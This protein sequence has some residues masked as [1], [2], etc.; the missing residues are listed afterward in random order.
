MDTSDGAAL[1]P[2]IISGGAPVPSPPPKCRRF[3]RLIDWQSF[4]L[5]ALLIFA[6]Y[7]F[8][9]SP[10]I[11]L[12][13][14]GILSTG[15]MY[16]GVPHP[17]GFPL[18]TIYA[19][20]FTVLIPFGNIA[21]RVAISSAIATSIACGLVALLVS[22]C[23]TLLMEGLQK[24]QRLPPKSERWLRIVCGCVAGMSFGLSGSVWSHS[25]VANWWPLTFAMFAAVICLLVRWSFTPEKTRYLYEAF[26]LYGL[27]LTKSQSL[28]VA[29]LG[30]EL[31]I[32]LVNPALGRDLFAVSAW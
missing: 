16:G 24:F 15:A 5:T 31:F 22:R 9:L 25:V 6:V 17:P 7:I 23:G 28:I 20:L 19:H 13:W 8:I 2:D 30:L 14:A 12:S 11:D 18:W 10:S 3:F 29:L 26:F 1:N 4:S 32:L 27:A 21:W